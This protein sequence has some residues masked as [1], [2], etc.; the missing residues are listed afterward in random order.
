MTSPVGNHV[1]STPIICSDEPNLQFY[2]N[3]CGGHTEAREIDIARHKLV[4]QIML[5]DP[6]DGAV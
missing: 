5:D 1:N 6:H 3:V 4:S 2:A